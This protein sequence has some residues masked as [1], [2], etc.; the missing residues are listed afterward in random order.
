MTRQIATARQRALIGACLDL[1]VPFFWAG[2]GTLL[3]KKA[4][5]ASVLPEVVAAGRT[6]L[7]FEGFELDGSHIRPRLDLV[8]DLKLGT[9][10]TDPVEVISAWPEDVWVDVALGA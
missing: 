8:A 4:G 7:G 1:G 6:V 9:P 3:I 5:L 10:G 2:P